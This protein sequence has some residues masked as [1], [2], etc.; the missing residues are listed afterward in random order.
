MRQ[1]KDIAFLLR[2]IPLA[3][4]FFILPLLLWA[5]KESGNGDNDGRIEKTYRESN[6]VI[7]NPER[8]FM[9]LFTVVAEGPALNKATLQGLKNDKISIIHR[10]YY[11][12]KF[13]NGPMSQTQLDLFQTDFNTLRE[14]GMKVILCFAYTGIDYV[15]VEDAIA[16]GKDVSDAPLTVVKMHL[17]QLKPLLEANKD[18]IAFVQAGFVGA[19]GEFHS[20]T[21]NLTTPENAR[22]VIDKMLE[23][24]PDEI[25]LQMRTPALKRMVFSGGPL[26]E[27]T[28][29]S[30]QGSSRVGHYNHCFLT[31]ETDYGTYVNPVADRAYISQEAAFVPTGGE[32]CP[33]TEGTPSCQKAIEEM[34]L[35]KWTYLNL[36]WYKPTIDAW[37][38]AGC[39]TEF[40]RRLGYRFT[41]ASIRAPEE[42]TAGGDLNIQIN[43]RNT[44]YAPVYNP[45]KTSLVLKNTAGGEEH[46]F[47]LDID[48]RTC[49]P[50]VPL[51][52]EKKIAL[53]GLGAGT[54]DLY[55]KIADHVDQLRDRPE[56]SIQLAT[57]GV[58]YTDKGLNKLNYQLKVN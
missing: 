44:G 47:P 1:S 20:S 27:V 45:K 57:T 41:L 35:L 29:Y 30:G 40:Q 32:T 3:V 39:F 42:V 36:N 51:S 16:E 56:Y 23:A 6:D 48:I 12:E 37:R 46:Y 2:Q 13:K 43:I 7:F 33:P 52:I 19:W 8:G 15:W 55:L 34:K 4:T 50:M 53:T 26:N 11:L 17:D 31:G 22:A 14:V 10:N 28:A 38:N 49:K 24:F 58:E 54:Y 5:C 18:V 25:M 21:N 9:N